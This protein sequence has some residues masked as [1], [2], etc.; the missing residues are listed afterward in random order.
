MN[1]YI[2]SASCVF[3]H[4]PEKVKYRL[5]DADKLF[6]TFTSSEAQSTNVSDQLPD[7]LERIIFPGTKKRVGISNNRISATFNFEQTDKTAEESFEI[8][9]ANVRK[10]YAAASKFHP[11]KM[12]T[13]HGVVLHIAFPVNSNSDKKT[14][15]PKIA[16]FLST[17]FYCGEKYGPAHS[18]EL[19]VGF[20]T[21]NFLFRSIFLSS[22][23]KR[24]GQVRGGGVVDLMSIPLVETGIQLILDVNDKPRSENLSPY[25]MAFEDV[26]D[27]LSAFFAESTSRKEFLS[28]EL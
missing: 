20:L 17:K 27:E 15:N 1:E 21:K 18:F 8:S 22:Y 3:G 16:E 13:E 14:A 2:V 23:E 25:P 7:D 12:F 28:F 6:S 19:K 10:F 5:E 24:F 4:L 26:I 11:G 9:I